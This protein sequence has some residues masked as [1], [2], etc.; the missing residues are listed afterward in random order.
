MYQMAYY[1]AATK[2]ANNITFL[3]TKGEKSVCFG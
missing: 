3:T 2:T 1:N